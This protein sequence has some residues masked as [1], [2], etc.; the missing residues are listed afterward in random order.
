MSHQRNIPFLTQA[1]IFGQL[2]IYHCRNRQHCVRRVLDSDCG[3][4]ILR[5]LLKIT[6]RSVADLIMEF[7]DT[8][9]LLVEGIII[10]QQVT[11]HQ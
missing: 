10:L 6:P 8:I 3:E 1:I 9:H 4:M 5:V 2:F 7:L 11:S